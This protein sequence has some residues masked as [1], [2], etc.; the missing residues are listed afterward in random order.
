MVETQKARTYLRVCEAIQSRLKKSAKNKSGY[1]TTHGSSCFK[2]C[3]T[4]PP[5]VTRLE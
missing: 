2:I 4:I 5:C 1:R 3:L